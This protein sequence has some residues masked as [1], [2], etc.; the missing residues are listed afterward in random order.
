MFSNIVYKEVD[1][2]KKNVG[3]GCLKITEPE[4]SIPPGMAVACIIH[5]ETALPTASGHPS[6]NLGCQILALPTG[7]CVQ[8][9]LCL[10]L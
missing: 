7:E 1:L 2:E 9:S 6:L 8:F 5:R 3:E 4:V 10:Q